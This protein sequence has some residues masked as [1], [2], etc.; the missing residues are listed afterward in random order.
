MS[1]TITEPVNNEAAN[2]YTPPTF[3]EEAELAP[4]RAL[5]RSAVISVVLAV[6]S[7]LG[8]LFVPMLAVALAAL[9]M[10]LI[11]MQSIRRYPLE[12]TGLTVAKIGTIVG[13][14]IF[15]SGTIY[16]TYVYLTEVPE[17]YQRITFSQLQPD[18]VEEPDSPIP[19]QAL[20][21]SGKK[22]FVKG[23]TH[24]FISSM[25]KV[26]H[27]VLVP[28][29]GE[30]CFGDKTKPTHMIEVKVTDPRYKVKY[31]LRRLK[32]I[33]EFYASDH[34]DHSLGLGEVYY[35]LKADKVE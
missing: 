3:G 33:G 29:L 15:V 21:L 1:S 17:G 25:G 19:S 35:H 2:P 16:H 11:A 18:F 14:L 8:Y 22:V 20:E 4:Y 10:G 30:C 28:D 13:G 24:K 6:V 12:Y 9:V 5:S 32:L 31:A 27:F 23:Y 7:L 34:P 26:D